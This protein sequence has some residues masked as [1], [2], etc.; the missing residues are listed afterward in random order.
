MPESIAVELVPHSSEWALQAQLER[1]R[2]YQALEGNLVT[3]H[4]IGSTAVPCICAKPI[5]DLLPVVQSLADLDLTQPV[6]ESLGYQWW[7]EYG[8]PGR[9]YCTL[10]DPVTGR[11]LIQL[12]CFQ[13]GSPEIEK[14]LAFRDYLRSH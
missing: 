13:Q 9:R 4:H 8:I 11:R 5:L 1:A 3:V 2:L 12:H 14:H 10:D 6:L 7:R